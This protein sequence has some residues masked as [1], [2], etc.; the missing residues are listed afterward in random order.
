[1]HKIKTNL[2]VILAIFLCISAIAPTIAQPA[3]KATFTGTQTPASPQ[4][5]SPDLVAFTTDGGTVHVRNLNGAGTISLKI[6]TQSPISGTTSS[7]I[8]VDRKVTGEG[9][10]KFAMTW[11][12]SDGTFVGNILGQIAGANVYLDCHGVLQ[13]TG[14]YE[15]WT[16]KLEGSKPTAGPTPFS[17]TGTIITP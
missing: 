6:G 4:P 3:E 2:L 10:V 14:V 12:F 9:N 13:C 8:Q 7:I 17:W 11:T 5:P 1:M 15:G 16:L